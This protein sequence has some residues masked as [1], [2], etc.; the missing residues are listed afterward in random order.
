MTIYDNNCVYYSSIPD[1]DFLAVVVSISMT[2]SSLPFELTGCL[3]ATLLI[4]VSGS[5]IEPILPVSAWHRI[6]HY[7]FHSINSSKLTN[8]FLDFCLFASC[9]SRSLLE[10]QD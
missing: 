6:V 2:T 9:S 8:F 5:S 10:K 3:A 7:Y 1:D 4:D